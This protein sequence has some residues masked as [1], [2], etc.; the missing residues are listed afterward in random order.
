LVGVVVATLITVAAVGL[1]GGG[2]AADLTVMI[3][4]AAVVLVTVGTV[5]GVRNLVNVCDLRRE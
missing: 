1:L 2:I 4:I 5:N 3:V